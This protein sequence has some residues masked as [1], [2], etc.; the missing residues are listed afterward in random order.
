MSQY[1]RDSYRRRRSEEQLMFQRIAAE[2]QNI[3]NFLLLQQD[4][5]TSVFIGGNTEGIEP[6]SGTD[7]DTDTY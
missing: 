4:E 7:T 6:I 5:G 3:Q 1:L 2:Q